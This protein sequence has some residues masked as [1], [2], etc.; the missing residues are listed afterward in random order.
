MGLPF[1]TQHG[2]FKYQKLLSQGILS[3]GQIIAILHL[4]R[5]RFGPQESRSMIQCLTVL[6]EPTLLHDAL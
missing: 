6:K 2:C 5:S 4:D 1:H 3:P